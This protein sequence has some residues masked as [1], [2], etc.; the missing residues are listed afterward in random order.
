MSFTSPT[1]KFGPPIK[2][3]IGTSFIRVK[4]TF[5]QRSD[6]S[7]IWEIIFALDFTVLE[8][9]FI[10]RP[11]FDVGLLRSITASLFAESLRRVL[12]S[13]S[14]GNETLGC[15][16]ADLLSRGRRGFIDEMSLT[17]LFLL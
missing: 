3:S 6:V 12:L 7:R 11:N 2:V 13:M 16:F 17:L 14:W 9:Y 4:A 8:N 10:S 5:L 1:M 15:F